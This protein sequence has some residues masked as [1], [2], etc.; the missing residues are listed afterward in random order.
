[1]TP[2]S[3]ARLRDGLQPIEKVL[4]LEEMPVFSRASSEQLAAMAAITR[5]VKMAEGDLL[6]RE[7]D[8]PAIYIVLDGELSLEPMK[9]GTPAHAGA[10]DAIGVYETLGGLDAVGWRGHVTKAGVLLRLDREALFDL[11]SDQID[12]LQG[13]FGALQRARAA[14]K[15]DAPEPAVKG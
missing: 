13:L 2:P 11:L 3:Q 12:L 10:G 7:A 15:A 5:E 1:M 8:A 14:R 6:F 9:G 4:I